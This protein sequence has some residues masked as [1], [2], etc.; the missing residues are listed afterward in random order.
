MAQITAHY[1][2]LI[3]AAPEQIYAVFADYH[4]HHPAILPKQ[5]FGPLEVLEGG[6]G[7]GTLIHVITK[8]F[9]KEQRLTMRVTEPEPGR[10]LQETEVDTGMQTTFSVEPSEQPGQTRVGITIAWDGKPGL[11]GFFERLLMPAGMRM[12]FRKELE[13]VRAYVR[14]QRVAA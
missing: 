1:S 5:F 14:E 9:G 12:V 7:A 10:K 11:A 4:T 6:R 2:T 3:A 8:S 13:L